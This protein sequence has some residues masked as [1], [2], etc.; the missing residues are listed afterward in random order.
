MNMTD[1]DKMY[2]MMSALQKSI[3]W[4][5]INPSRYF[6][7]ELIDMGRPH[8]AFG[9]LRIIAAEDI[10]LADPTIVGYVSEC[11]GSIDE[12]IKQYGIDKKDVI[13]VPEL[14]EIVDRAVIAE[15]LSFKSR[16]LP[17]ATFATLF[18]IYKNEKFSKSK[19]EYFDLFVDA[20]E[21]DNEKKALYYAFIVDKISG[22]KKP[23]LRKIQEQIG[24]R[25]EDL[26]Q[27]WIDEYEKHEKLLNLAGSIVLLCRDLDFTHGEYKDM[28]HH[29]LSHP[30]KATKIPDRAYD[31]HTRAGRDMGRG[32]KYFFNL[33]GTIKKERF[34]ND[35]EEAGTDAF[36]SADREGLADDD[37]IINAIKKKRQAPTVPLTI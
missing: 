1:D 13:K 18:D 4:R 9:Q 11:L 27:K 19:Y 15:A 37:E 7:R 30:I 33:S 2:N 26:I 25:N 23:I 31:K 36:Y 3:R 5:E 22:D 24:K 35:W 16:L 29:H 20:L 12:L 28:I 14:P 8:A 6:A 21:K 32:L 34:P 17:M 10:G